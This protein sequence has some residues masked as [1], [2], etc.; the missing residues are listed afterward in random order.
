MSLKKKIKWVDKK[1]IDPQEIIKKDLL[2]FINVGTNITLIDTN[3][4]KDLL[5]ENSFKK[6]RVRKIYDRYKVEFDVFEPEIGYWRHPS[7]FRKE[8][9]LT[10]EKKNDNEYIL[11]VGQQKGRY[12]K[13]KMENYD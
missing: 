4:N 7:F 2:D 8:L 6:R 11:I 1:N 13:Y 10:L 3:L 5:F 12:Y 9:K